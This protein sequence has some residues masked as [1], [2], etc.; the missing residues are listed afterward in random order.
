MSAL[1]KTFITPEQYLEIEDK[2]ESRSE[3]FAGQMFAM[4]GASEPH[5]TLVTN[6]VV[7]LGLQFRKRPCRVYST[8]MK[9]KVGKT[10]LF[11]YPDV[12]AV[13]GE[14]E[15][16]NSKNGVLLNPTVIIEVLSDSTEL[17]DRTGKFEH[18]RRLPS[19]TDYL[20]VSQ[21]TACVEQYRRQTDNDWL[22]TV[23]EGR[24]QSVEIESIGCRLSLA[25][26]YDKINL[27]QADSLQLRTGGLNED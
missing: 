2:A 14:A 11:T 1:E 23:T 12:V 13:C 4:A 9:V 27:P 8:D 24:E 16:L 5:I 21:K 22:L 19:L 17:Y 7:E 20:M 25:D 26:I 18:Y 10:G 15:L 3:Y 6:L